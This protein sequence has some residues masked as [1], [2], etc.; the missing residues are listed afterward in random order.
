MRELV[1]QHAALIRTVPQDIAQDIASQIAT[2]QMR[3][4]RAETIARDIRR[5][6]PEITKSRVAMLARTEVSSTATSISEARA[7]HLSLPC[8]EW[9]SSEDRRVRPSH[10][11][12]DHVIV[13]WSDPPAPEA[14][15]GIRSKLGHYQAGK[16]PNCRCDANV[17]VDLGQITFPAKVYHDGKIERMGRAKF[18]NLYH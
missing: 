7:A 12:M 17:I 5:R 14:L 10:R 13:F 4:E 2:R 9:L 8:Y 11:L 3:G 15:A 18:L 16:V 1:S 6:I